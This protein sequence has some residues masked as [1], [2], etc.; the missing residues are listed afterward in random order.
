M[1]RSPD[2][3]VQPRPRPLSPHLT[4][5][6]P[7]ITYT[8]SIIHRITGA[9]LYFGTVL[10]ALWLIAAAGSREMFDCVD[11]FFGSVV[12]RLILL[13]YTWALLHHML[14]GIR[15]F[16]WDTATA[17]DKQTASK[18]GWATLTGSV[19]LTIAAWI[20]GYMMRGGWA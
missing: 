13:G 8:M 4:V 3:P 6:R 10:V 11:W 12:G 2:S 9:A 20:A 17:M 5:W 14:G 16:I 18:L 19:V 15:H 7:T 1:S